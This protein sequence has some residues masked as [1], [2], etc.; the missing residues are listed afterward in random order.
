MFLILNEGVNGKFLVKNQSLKSFLEWHFRSWL[1]E[2]G[3]RASRGMHQLCHREGDNIGKG[4]PGTTRPSPTVGWL[5]SLA[6]W[7]SGTS[8]QHLRIICGPQGT[9]YRVWHLKRKAAG[10]RN[11]GTRLSAILVFHPSFQE[12][13]SLYWIPFPRLTVSSLHMSRGRR[14]LNDGD[15]GRAA[16]AP[17]MWVPTLSQPG[18]PWLH[19][20]LTSWRLHRGDSRNKTFRCDACCRCGAVPGEHHGKLEKPHI[21][22]VVVTV[23]LLGGSWGSSDGPALSPSLGGCPPPSAIV[24]P[25]PVVLRDILAAFKNYMWPPSH[26]L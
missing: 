11:P 24:F 25:S 12:E 21:S 2:R 16:R 15:E 19:C 18:A 17:W 26:H 4:G 13:L 5:S 8:W 3:C 1:L 22:L 14:C 20:G 10:V 6:L 23:L 7:S 9:T